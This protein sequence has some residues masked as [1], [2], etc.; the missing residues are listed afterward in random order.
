M[1][2]DKDYFHKWYLSNKE[3]IADRQKR[4]NREFVEKHGVSRYMYNKIKEREKIIEKNKLFLKRT[5]K[6]NNN[7]V[8]KKKEKIILYF[9]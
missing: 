9:D 1:V 2:Y 3:K 8:I 7:N 5:K 4:Y 6:I